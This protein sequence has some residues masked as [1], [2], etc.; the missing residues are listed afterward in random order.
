METTAL[1]AAHY[2]EDFSPGMS[3]RSREIEVSLDDIRRF[4]GEFDPQPFHLDAQA[5]QTSLF[6]ALVAS[7][8]HTAALTMR[9]LVDSDL[10]IA[11]GI[12]GAG[13]EL[14]WPAALRPGERIHVEVEVTAVRPLRTRPNS[15]L[16]TTLT[17]TLTASG[18]LVQ[19]LS[20]NLLVPRRA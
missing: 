4:A 9:L 16:V 18:T 6:G 13:G 3:F 1:P 19:E 7:G 15:G 2:F 12:I 11:G 5:A 10:S 17:R 14:K 20:A 8:W